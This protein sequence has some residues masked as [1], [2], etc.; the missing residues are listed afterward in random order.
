MR[1]QNDTLRR[2]A[3]AKF[4]ELLNAMARD[5]ALMIYLDAPANRKG[6]ANE[7]LARELMEL[8][9]LGIGNYSEADVKEA[10]RAL[11]GW[12]VNDGEFK[13]N[14]AGHDDG[15][16]TILGKKG[17][18][19]GDDLIKLL[20]EHAA[21]AE[22]IAF[23]LCRLFFGE[24]GVEPAAR[25]A[26]AAG[27]REHN[28]EVGWAAGVILRSREFF[29]DA[30]MGTKIMG[31]V[32]FVVG[33]ARALE[34]FDPAPSTL[35]LADWCGRLGQDLFEPPNVGGWPAGKAWV[36]ARTL[37]SRANYITALLE[38]PSAGR[39]TAFDPAAFAQRHGFSGDPLDCFVPLFVGR[40][41]PRERVAGMEGR[42]LVAA[43]LASP[44][45]QLN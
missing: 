33:T 3:R 30:N 41:F 14:T 29:A 20:L 22:R 7:N 5:P 18:W 25:Q 31:P 35:A 12:T 11:T 39:P 26:L 16:K 45:A 17:K 40:D 42:K 34:L 1:R 37:I 15:E 2:Y 10:A 36:S 13:N 24:A 23:K 8:F 9:T 19:A 21:I 43:L 6:H 4:S 38:G 28:L 32:D 27:L 44:E